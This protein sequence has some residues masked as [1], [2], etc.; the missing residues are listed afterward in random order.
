[1]DLRFEKTEKAIRNAFL[2]L[3]SKKALEK[4]KVKELC[5]LCMINKSTFYSHYADIYALSDKLQNEVIDTIVNG[6]S[7][8]QPY[9]PGNPEEFTKGLFLSFF[10]QRTLLDTLFSGREMGRLPELMEKAI[11][12]RIFE[13]HPEHRTSTVYNIVLSY[14]IQGAFYAFKNNSDTDPATLMNVICSINSSIGLLQ[15]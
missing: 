2:E 4:I 15:V 10:S 9:T 8:E 11:K 7:P 12:K 3:R 14:C 5:T 6:V 1:M 13:I